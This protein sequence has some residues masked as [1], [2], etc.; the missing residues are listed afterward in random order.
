MQIKTGSFPVG[1]LKAVCT[2]ALPA[3]ADVASTSH[4]VSPGP[5]DYKALG[6]DIALA[7]AEDA[8]SISQLSVGNGGHVYNTHPRMLLLLWHCV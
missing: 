3:L 1:H 6:Q 2:G 5:P 7:G 8:V 4:R